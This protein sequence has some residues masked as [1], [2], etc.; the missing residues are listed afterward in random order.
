MGFV[1]DDVMNALLDA[2]LGSGHISPMPAIL[3]I[4]LSSTQPAD[5]GTNVT[6]PTDPSYGPAVVNNDTT[7]WPA[8]SARTKSNANAIVFPTPTGTWGTVSWFAL[9]D[10]GSAHST[11]TFR[12]WGQLNAP[13]TITALSGAPTFGVGTLVVNGPG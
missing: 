4:A 8:A 13:R 2:F 7:N 12:G 5:D 3:D 10:N 11:S 9:Y 6:E 1:A